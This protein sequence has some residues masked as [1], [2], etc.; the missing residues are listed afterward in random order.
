RLCENLAE[1]VRK[2]LGLTAAYRLAWMHEPPPAKPAPAGQKT[3]AAD[4]APPEITINE[5]VVRQ[6]ADYMDFTGRTQAVSTVELRARVTG[7]LDKVQFKEGAEVKQGAVLFEID[8]RPYQ[9]ALDQA[10]AALISAQ[11]AAARAEAV[12]NRTLALVKSNAAS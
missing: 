4:P 5:P 3:P 9:A 8:P 1:E 12:C 6:V 7:Y 10:R 11:A 2:A